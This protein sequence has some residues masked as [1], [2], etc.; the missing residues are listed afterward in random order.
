MEAFLFDEKKKNILMGSISKNSI[1]FYQFYNVDLNPIMYAYHKYKLK[2]YQEYDFNLKI[3]NK[4][5]YDIETF[6]DPPKFPD[7]LK[8]ERP[9][10]A[11]ATYN[12]IENKATL[13]Y[14]SEVTAVLTEVGPEARTYKVNEDPSKIPD[15]VRE[16]YYELCEHNRD[17]LIEDLTIEVKDY[18]DEVQLLIDFFLDRRKEQSLFLIGFNSDLFDNPYIVNRIINLVGENKAKT[19]ISEFGELS[20]SAGKYYSWPDTQLVDLL[21]LYKP[22]DAGG[23]G[24]GSSLP[25]YKLNTIAEEELGLYKLDL[26]GGFNENYLNKIVDYLAYNLLDTLL[27]YFLDKKL[28]FLELQWSLNNYNNSLMSSTIAGRSLIYT[29]RNNLHYMLNNKALRFKKLNREV[30]FPGKM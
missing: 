18:T 17:Y 15:L 6:V 16:K 1:P 11:I 25:N 12:S 2:N 5:Y 28:R 3:L 29:V 27:V 23:N 14:L 9:I 4:T 30:Y 7:P 10:N 19:I 13:Y 21:I 22:V 26:P 20:K 8:A 24:F